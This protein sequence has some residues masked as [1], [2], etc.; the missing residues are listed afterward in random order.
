MKEWINDQEE[1]E[2]RQLVA[3]QKRRE[4]DDRAQ[5]EES[6]RKA[7]QE[8]VEKQKRH[9]WEQEQEKK[10]KESEE[11]NRDLKAK[12][13]EVWRVRK[14]LEGIHRTRVAEQEAKN[15]AVKKQVDEEMARHIAIYDKERAADWEETLEIRKQLKKILEEE[16]AIKNKL[17]TKIEGCLGRRTQERLDEINKS[18][19]QNP[20]PEI[21]AKL[22]PLARERCIL[23]ARERDL[24]TRGRSREEALKRVREETT[25]RIRG[26]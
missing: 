26:V 8:E 21:K 17:K 15:E 7:I 23:A 9:A 16:A 18:R 10:R 25:K 3:I 19:H 24:V 20:P 1:Y 12:Q 2:Q 5:K 14:E 13:D 22:E 4:E 11:A 6:S